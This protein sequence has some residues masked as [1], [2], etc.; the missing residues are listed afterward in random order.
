MFKQVLYTQWK[1]AQ[2]G[3]LVACVAA[4]A[5]PAFALASLGGLDV[6]LA[7]VSTVVN[8]MQGAGVGYGI[9]AVL[10]GMWI[11]AS[12][13]SVNQQLDYVYALTRPVPRWYFV[14]LRFGG[15]T[16]LVGAVSV[17]CLAGALVAAAVVRLPA[18]LHAYPVA[19]SLR[20]ALALFVSF[21]AS[22]GLLGAASKTLSRSTA[23][24]L[25]V[26]LGI[27]ILDATLLGGALSGAIG[28]FLVSRWSPIGVY[29]GRWML[30]DV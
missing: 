30:I 2:W 14:L 11:A 7:S 17:A 13:W 9:L 8:T 21:G 5:M 18:T 3:L 27:V 1:W 10:A 4:F 28:K 19:L 20:F 12:G 29:I 15:G 24:G 22:F 16:V 23:I 26:A 6:S 25:A